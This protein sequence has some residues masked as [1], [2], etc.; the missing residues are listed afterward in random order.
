MA[1]VRDFKVSE[2]VISE[3]CEVLDHEGMCSNDCAEC[4]FNKVVD[5]TITVTVD[6]E[7]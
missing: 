4:P 7:S 6:S 1:K 3:I 2:D 5:K